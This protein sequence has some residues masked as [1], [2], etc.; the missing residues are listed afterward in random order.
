MSMET[1]RP[2]GLTLR[3]ADMMTDLRLMSGR[4]M[5]SINRH[6]SALK[7]RSHMLGDWRL[8]IGVGS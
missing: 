8:V 6:S 2:D 3:S 7:A 1:A 5:L 4:M